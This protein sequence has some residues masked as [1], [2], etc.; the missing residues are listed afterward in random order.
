L[1]R[2][3]L[4]HRASRFRR[5]VWRGGT[6]ADPCDH[7]A[8]RAVA[9]STAIAR[10]EDGHQIKDI[11]TA[12]ENAVL[13]AHG[14]KPRRTATAGL[15]GECQAAL[16]EIHLHFHDL[17]HEAGS[18]KLEAGWPLHA[19]SIWLGHANVTTTAR[20]V[21]V[22]SDYLHELNERAPLMLVKS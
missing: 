15:L 6:F 19:V 3:L 13:K 4:R 20:Y 7:S 12:W 1:H 5:P 14:V 8:R 9:G 17:R 11:K 2:F 10:R 21:N 22:K 18:R 16:D